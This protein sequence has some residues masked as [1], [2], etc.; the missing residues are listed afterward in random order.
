MTSGPR[1]KKVKVVQWHRKHGR[2][3]RP[4]LATTRLAPLSVVVSMTLIACGG[5]QEGAPTAAIDPI[6]G[7]GETAVARGELLPPCGGSLPDLSRLGASARQQVQQRH[8]AV[9]AESSAEAYGGARY[10]LDG[11]EGS[12]PG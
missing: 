7:E 1:F 11:C 6:V 12:R 8:T 3:G 4:R 10:D 9:T 2:T 5:L